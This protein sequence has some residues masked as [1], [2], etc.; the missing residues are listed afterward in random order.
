MGWT[1]A[2]LDALELRRNS[3]AGKPA[4]RP[5][6]RVELGEWVSDS[7]FIAGAIPS[8][9][10]RKRAIIKNGPDGPT[11]GLITD[12]EVQKQLAALTNQCAL[13]WMRRHKWPL[14]EAIVELKFAVSHHR[15]D[16][17]NQANAACDVLVAAEILRTDSVMHLKELHLTFEI[18]P[19][20]EEGMWIAVKGQEYIEK[21][22]RA[23]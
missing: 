20:G 17:D 22:V 21:V 6:V 13:Y 18:V 7:F 23:A 15:Q 1:Q 14:T 4:S 3:E 16:L 10:N 11:P 5:I 19:K 12:G 9:K 8:K 2:D